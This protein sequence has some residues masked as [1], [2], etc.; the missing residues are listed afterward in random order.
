MDR[1]L[2]LYVFI[3]TFVCNQDCLVNGACNF[4]YGPSGSRECVL[5]VGYD[6][7]QWTTCLSNNYIKQSSNNEH[8]CH[9]SFAVYCYYQCMLEEHGETN[10]MIR[11]SL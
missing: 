6:R 9:I 10:G 4:L 5:I 7:P 8:E 11:I 1:K 2:K 3:L